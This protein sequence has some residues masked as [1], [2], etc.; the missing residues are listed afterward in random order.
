MLG[1]KQCHNHRNIWAQLWEYEH[2]CGIWAQPSE[3]DHN[4]CNM[5][6]TV[7]I[8]SKP[9]EYEHNLGNMS[10]TVGIWAQPS[11]YEQNRLN[12]N[13]HCSYLGFF[14]SC[15]SNCFYERKPPTFCRS[16]KS[17]NELNFVHWLPNIMSSINDNENGH[18]NE[19]EMVGLRD[20][21]GEWLRSI[22][23]SSRN[24]LNCVSDDKQQSD[25]PLSVL[26]LRCTIRKLLGRPPPVGVATG[27]LLMHTRGNLASPTGG[28][29]PP[30]QK[31]HQVKLSACSSF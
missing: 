22:D 10:T 21:E 26:M 14:W 5:S 30:G 2:N 13:Y 17:S 16:A 3:Y 12:R 24:T 23:I 20:Q 15:E 18:E 28:S 1:C 29:R 9:L 6:R 4:R 7:G 11:K 27:A 31:C 8:W 19:M 25:N